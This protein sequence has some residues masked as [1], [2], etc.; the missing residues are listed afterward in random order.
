MFRS[1]PLHKLGRD[2]AELLAGL[3]VVDR[4]LRFLMLGVGWYALVARGSLWL[5]IHG[6][7]LLRARGNPSQAP[8]SPVGSSTPPATERSFID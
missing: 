8:S 3:V 2:Q 7:A 5:Q 1:T 4:T 6:K